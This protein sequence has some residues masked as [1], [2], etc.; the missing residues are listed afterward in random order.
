M[1]R[2]VRAH[3]EPYLADVRSLFLEYAAGL[4]VDLHLQGFGDEL[5]ALPGLYAPP[6]GAILLA[7]DGK[8]PVGCVALRPLQSGTCEMKRLF[9]IPQR[10]RSGV[11]RQLAEAI[12]GEAREV[13]YDTMLLDTLETMGPAIALY[14]SLGFRRCPEYGHHPYPGT[15][16]MRL[17][18]REATCS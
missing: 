16:A 8:L 2:L 6:A 5:A 11:G 10:R 12:V 9:V 18:L 7:R 4:P 15:I 3:V 1:I 17:N 14:A 13:G